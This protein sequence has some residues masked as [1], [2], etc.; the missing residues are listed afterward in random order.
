MDSF[1]PKPLLQDPEQ[2]RIVYHGGCHDGFASALVFWYLL[3]SKPTYW[4]F[5]YDH[6]VKVDLF[7]NCHVVL[8]DFSW[9]RDVILEVQKVAKSLTVFDHHST[10]E[11][12]LAGLP[13]CQ[14]KMD[15][16]GCKICFDALSPHY[17][18]QPPKN[19]SWLLDYIEDRDLWRWR[20]PDSKAINA[21]LGIWPRRDFLT[22]DR[23]LRLPFDALR[24]RLLL[25]GGA[26]LL[27]EEMFVLSVSKS[28]F[29]VTFEGH[30]AFQV[31][32]N[33][34]WS[35]VGNYLG[36]K[37]DIAIMWAQQNNGT[38]RY[39][40]RTRSDSIHVGELAKKYGGGGHQKAAGFVVPTRLEL[41]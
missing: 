32:T 38:Y 4:A 10:A 24:D 9:K 2:V 13:F 7:E 17:Q 11:K 29:P 27:Q 35:E 23:R 5:R 1:D 28:A 15:S 3:G 8:V 25:E 12:E 30:S 21:A 14:F 6:P 18:V 22:W 16:C 40:L 20:Q 34:L 26:L 31:N 41:K 36:E 19:L 33:F 39:E 37:A